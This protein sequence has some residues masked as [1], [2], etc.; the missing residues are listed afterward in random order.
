MG[1]PEW[2]RLKPPP[3][4]FTGKRPAGEIQQPF[5]SGR[6]STPSSPLAPF[7]LP[8]LSESLS[9]YVHFTEEEGEAQSG[10]ENL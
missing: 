3:R 7:T 2:R 8:I 1:Y 6:C 9:R 4:A 5:A 10:D